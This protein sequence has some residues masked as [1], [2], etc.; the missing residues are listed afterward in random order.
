MR[1]GNSIRALGKAFRNLDS[2]DGNNRVD[3]R[4]FKF[5]L[6]EKGVK[7][8]EDEIDVLFIKF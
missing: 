3:R 1:N 2:Y 6:S 8:S 5:G 7:L 4:E